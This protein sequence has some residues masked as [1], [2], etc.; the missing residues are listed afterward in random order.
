MQADGHERAFSRRAVQGA[1]AV[2]A[3]F[4]G[5]PIPILINARYLVR[6]DRDVFE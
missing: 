6:N 3:P 4:S 1:V 2:D 5:A